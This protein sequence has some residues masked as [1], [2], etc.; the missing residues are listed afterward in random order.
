MSELSGPRNGAGTTSLVL[1][2]VMVT[3]GL[4]PVIWIAGVVGIVYGVI[5]R[6][7]VRVGVATN[8]TVAN[9]GLALSIIGTVFWGGLKFMAGWNSI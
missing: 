7:R 9:W 5:G 6:R 2:I 8:G 1:G 4:L 3:L